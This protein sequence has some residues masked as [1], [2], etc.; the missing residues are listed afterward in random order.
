[1]RLSIVATALALAS[2]ASP[3]FADGPG[4]A[5]A[6]T[7]DSRHAR[8]DGPGTIAPQL[9]SLAEDLKKPPFT[10]SKTFKALDRKDARLTEGASASFSSPDGQPGSLSYAGHVNK[11]NR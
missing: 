7:I 10:A 1:M 8:P 9:A 3:A 11:G 4:G 2:G 6:C 5:A